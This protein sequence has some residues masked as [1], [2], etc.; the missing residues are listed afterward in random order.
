MRARGF[1]K[2]PFIFLF[3]IYLTYSYYSLGQLLTDVLLLKEDRLLESLSAIFLLVSSILLFS[4]ANRTRIKKNYRSLTTFFLILSFAVFVWFAEEISWGQRI[5]NFNIR[6]IEVLN[7]QGEVNIHNLSVVQPLLHYVYFTV[8]LVVAVLCI[9]PQ[10]KRG[11]MHIFPNENLFFYFLLPSIY[12]LVGELMCNFPI[13]LKGH[14][15]SPS[16]TFQFQEAYEFLLAMGT[17]KFSLEKYRIMI[18]N[19]V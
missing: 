19:P 4:L 17:L 7:A 6:S 5:L 1:D 2:F 16:L 10:R 11:V 15:F 18:R 8:F 3:F 9:L 13:E 14:I 12:Y